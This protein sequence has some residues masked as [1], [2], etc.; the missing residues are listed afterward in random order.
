MLDI[1]F[2]I[3]Y[4]YL[5][6]RYIFFIFRAGSVIANITVYFSSFD[7]YQFIYLQDS[8][9]IENSLG[10]LSLNEW[11]GTYFLQPAGNFYLFA[12]SFHLTHVYVT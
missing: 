12:F 5:Y 2:I 3:Y 4:S 8:I 7:S 1:M 6:G 11:H 9:E 10:K